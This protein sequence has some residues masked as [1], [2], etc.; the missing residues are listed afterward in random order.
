MPAISV[1]FLVSNLETLRE[2]RLLQP[3]N[4]PAISVTF[5]VSNL[6]TLREVRLLHPV[7]IDNIHVTFCVL[8]L[9]TSR[10]VRLLQPANIPYISVTFCVLNLETSREVRLVQPANMALMLVTFSVLRYSRPSITVKSLHSKNQKEQFVGRALAKEESKITFLILFFYPHHR[11]LHTKRDKSG[12]HS[13]RTL[14][15][16]YLHRV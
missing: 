3:A 9:E 1:T 2:V 14:L 7:N 11:H 10:E 4:M 16:V 13:A 12:P 8:N 6:E 5:R 15:R